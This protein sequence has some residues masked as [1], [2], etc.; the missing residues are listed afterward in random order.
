MVYVSIFVLLA[1]L[2]NT[3][4]KDLVFRMIFY[5]MAVDPHGYGRL[6]THMFVL[7]VFLPIPFLVKAK[8]QDPSSEEYTFER[9]RSIFRLLSMLTFFIWIITSAIAFQY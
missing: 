6:L 3:I 8:E 4:D 5:Y 7:L 1:L 9:R 2:V